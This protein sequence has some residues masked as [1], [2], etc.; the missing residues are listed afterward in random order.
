MAHDEEERRLYGVYC[1]L[2]AA[3]RDQS[4]ALRGIADRMVIPYQD[5]IKDLLFNRETNCECEFADPEGPTLDEIDACA[6]DE[7][8]VARQDLTSVH[9]NADEVY[10]NCPRELASSLL[11]M[12][13]EQGAKLRDAVI[14]SVC[15]IIQ[16]ATGATEEEQ[17]EQLL[18]ALDNC[19]ENDASPLSELLA[20]TMQQLRSR[21]GNS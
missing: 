19:T 15:E 9:I 7:V 21:F 20:R 10:F 8:L 4:T 14:G 12:P 5:L 18:A 3:P 17:I 2:V 16:E 11:E 13:N 6:C 1:S